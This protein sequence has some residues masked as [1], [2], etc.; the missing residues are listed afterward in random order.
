[1][2]NIKKGGYLVNA[3]YGNIVHKIVDEDGGSKY[4]AGF[5]QCGHCG[6]GY[7]VPVILTATCRNIEAAKEIMLNTARVKKD[8]KHAIM[9][10]FEISQIER[11]YIM[12]VNYWHDPYLRKEFDDAFDQRNE[13]IRDRRVIQK[14]VVEK[15][16][17]EH[18]DIGEFPR[19]CRTQDQYTRISNAFERNFAPI[20]EN[21]QFIFPDVDRNKAMRDFYATT[22]K[23]YG[24]YKRDPAILAYYYILFGEDNNK[25]FFHMEDNYLCYSY[26][27]KEGL[28]RDRVELPNRILRK[29]IKAQ[30]EGRIGEIKSKY[31][32][33]RSNDP[34]RKLLN[35]T[36]VDYKRDNKGVSQTDKFKER[37]KKTAQLQKKT[38]NREDIEFGDI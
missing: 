35:E 18:N 13:F 1:M 27:G 9:D 26:Y 37:M 28:T 30:E 6:S 5:V 20:L 31:A 17:A 12:Q 36:E 33:G 34:A 10:V 32:V 21:G 14:Q 25:N 4:Y 15:M 11:D 23:R 19:E 3:Y 22:L 7:Y 16:M 2:K 24:I 38:S 29:V 8:H